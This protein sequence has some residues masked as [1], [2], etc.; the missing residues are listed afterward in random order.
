MNSLLFLAKSHKTRFEKLKL[1]DL[2]VFILLVLLGPITKAVFSGV[3]TLTSGFSTSG[4][5]DSLLS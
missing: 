5:Y 3:V 4:S 2:P 1:D